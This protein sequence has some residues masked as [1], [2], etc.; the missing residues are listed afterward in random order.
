MSM[1][2]LLKFEGFLQVMLPALDITTNDL[3]VSHDVT[4]CPSVWS[5]WMRGP[6]R[7]W[8]SGVRRLTA[9]PGW[10]VFRE[11]QLKLDKWQAWTSWI[12]CPIHLAES[13]P[14]IFMAK[15]MLLYAKIPASIETLA[16]FTSHMYMCASV[17]K[18]EP[19]HIHFAI[20]TRDLGLL[21]GLVL[22]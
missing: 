14:F 15:Y 4:S 5:Y 9:T 7:S 21:Q 6:G 12:S 3:R 18:K 10:M 1:V 16:L 19:T 13:S 20:K 2:N 11:I 17:W 22:G 8:S